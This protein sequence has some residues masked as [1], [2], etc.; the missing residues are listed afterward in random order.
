M[1]I[2]RRNLKEEE[3]LTSFNLA[4]YTSRELLV[5]EL[6]LSKGGA[7]SYYLEKYIHHP[8]RLKLKVIFTKLFFAITFGIIPVL[9]LLTYYEIVRLISQGSASIE[10]IYFI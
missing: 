10:S 7:K 5:E 1:K 6:V 4:K 8:F 3:V 2:K 9:P